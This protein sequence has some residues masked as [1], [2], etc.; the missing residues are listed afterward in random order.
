MMARIWIYLHTIDWAHG[1]GLAAGAVWRWLC[2]LPR[3]ITKSVAAFLGSP[4]VW[5][6]ACLFAF[7]GFCGGYLVVEGKL[8]RLQET[9]RV[10][11]DKQKIAGTAAAAL[12][13]EVGELRSANSR[14]SEDLRKALAEKP[15]VDTPASKSPPVAT[16]APVAAKRKPKP[17][18]ATSWW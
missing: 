10:L 3:R 2:A 1:L 15:A 13:M 5:L 6:A 4:Q 11:M 9:N 17:Q 14:L 12:G 8:H 7:A 18:P 16:P